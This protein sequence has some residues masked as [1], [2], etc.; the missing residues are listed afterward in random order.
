MRR[1]V[2]YLANRGL[3]NGA[4]QMLERCKAHQERWA[5]DAFNARA[6]LGR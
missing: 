6:R 2:T 4:R 5:R 1:L 3:D